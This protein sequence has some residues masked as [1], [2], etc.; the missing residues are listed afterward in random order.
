MSVRSDH[1]IRPTACW[2]VRR[3]RRLSACC[4]L[5]YDEKQGG[6]TRQLIYLMTTLAVAAA[7]RDK[8][9]RAEKCS[10]GRNK[11]RFEDT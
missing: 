3:R 8:R 6:I 10:A 2:C 9:N 4:T 11:F 5:G 7:G 1:F